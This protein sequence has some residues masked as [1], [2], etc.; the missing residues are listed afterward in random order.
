M[1]KKYKPFFRTGAMGQLAFKFDLFTWAFITLLQVASIIFLWTSVY[2]NTLDGIDAIINGFS[3]KE[4]I[5]YTIFINIFSFTSFSEETLWMINDE[6]KDGTIAMSFIKPI[7]YRIR[8][9]FINFGSV[10]MRNILIG[11]PCFIVGYV[12]FVIMGYITIISI[13]ILLIHILLFIVAL[14]IATLLNDA[15]N[16]IAGVLCFYTSSGFGINQMKQVIIS[17]LSG[18]L[19]PLSFFPGVFGKIVSF[20]PFAGMAQNPILI[21]LMKL[22]IL[23]S[24]QC[25]GLSLI[26]VIILEVIG[27]LLFNHAS[28]KVTVQGG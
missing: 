13:P 6:I 21:F 17:F 19:L 5:A 20:L 22:D 8:F 25:I 1:F 18:S 26:W 7:S 12:I 4:M 15:L 14:V 2:Q 3:F 27:W 10:F 16:Y 24:L 28:K 9:V 11:F 23:E